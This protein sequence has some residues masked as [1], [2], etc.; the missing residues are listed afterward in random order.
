[1]KFW[2]YFKRFYS[3][4]MIRRKS[5]RLEYHV[6]INE[7]IFVTKSFLA[8]AH[9][10]KITVIKIYNWRRLSENLNLS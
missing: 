8:A 9:D 2:M 7:A 6:G 1:M 3:V 5:L 10:K 4:G